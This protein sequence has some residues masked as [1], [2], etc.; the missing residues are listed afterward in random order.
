MGLWDVQ[1]VV[2]TGQ[3]VA[4]RPA[5]FKRWGTGDNAGNL[6]ITQEELGLTYFDKDAAS[7][8]KGGDGVSK[9]A[10]QLQA[11]ATIQAAPAEAAKALTVEQLDAEI[12]ARGY[13]PIS[14]V[15]VA[16]VAE[17]I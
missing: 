3:I 5:G 11:E 6:K 15:A 1:R 4:I 10:K 7:L 13:K 17:D 2:A 16:V 9:T 14:K 8:E 12:Q